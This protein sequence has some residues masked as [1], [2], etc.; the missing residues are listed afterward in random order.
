MT[1][2]NKIFASFFVGLAIAGAGMFLYLAVDTTERQPTFSTIWPATRALP[3]FE[4]IDHTGISVG[5]E[6]FRGHWSLVFFGF[7]HCPDICP[8]TLQMLSIAQK[9]LNESGEVAPEIVLVSVDPERDSPATMATYVGHFGDRVSGLTGDLNELQKLTSA[10]G[11]YFEKTLLGD[12]SYT[13]DHSAVVLV[14]NDAGAIQ[15]SFSA[16]HAVDNFIHDL[17][18]IVNS[19]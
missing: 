14:V 12:G 13:V 1:L 16:P 10:A 6:Y 5:P 17:P 7:T 4:L 3:A 11:I 9:K 19:N 2:Y 8:T 15:G 18:I